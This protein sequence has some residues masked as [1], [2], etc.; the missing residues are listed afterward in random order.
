MTSIPAAEVRADTYKWFSF[1]YIFI[2]LRI[3]WQ[4]THRN[5]MSKVTGQLRC[6]VEPGPMTRST[7]SRILLYLWLFFLHF[8]RLLWERHRW[9]RFRGARWRGWYWY[10]SPVFDTLF[11][12]NYDQ[13]QGITREDGA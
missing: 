13:L 11:P 3:S 8:D 9:D 5:L 6:L 12:E 10:H 7:F 4:P 2:W 1:F